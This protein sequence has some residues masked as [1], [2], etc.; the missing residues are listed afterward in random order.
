MEPLSDGGASQSQRGGGPCVGGAA[1]CDVRAT[2]VRGAWCV[3]RGAPPRRVALGA[4]AQGCSLLS[5]FCLLTHP[6]H[7]PSFF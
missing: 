6:G 2:C 5:R 7:F 3:V 4:E 1:A